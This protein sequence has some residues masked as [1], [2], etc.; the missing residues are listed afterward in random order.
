MRLNDRME[1]SA[2]QVEKFELGGTVPSL[3]EGWDRLC[4]Q[5]PSE[6]K[7]RLQEEPRD[8]CQALLLVNMSAQEALD[9]VLIVSGTS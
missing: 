5:A 4:A 8:G 1:N 7:N 6:W 2:S 9:A 3:C